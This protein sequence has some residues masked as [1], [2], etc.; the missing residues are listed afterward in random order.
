MISDF[1]FSQDLF[2]A[3]WFYP[4]FTPF[5]YVI[6]VIGGMAWMKRR[7][8]FS[9]RTFSVVHSSILCVASLIMFCG[10]A[11]GALKKARGS[12]SFSLFC[13][14]APE[15]SGTLAFWMYVYWLSKF[16]ELLDTAILVLR[17]KPVIFLHVFHH[18]VMTL[19]PWLWLVGNWTLVWFGCLMNCG[20]HVFMYGYYAASAAWDYRPWWRALLTTSQI[21]QFLMVFVA[22][23]AFQVTRFSG[24]LC[25]GDGN[26]IW[27][28]QGVN[29]VFLFFFVKFFVDT[30]MRKQKE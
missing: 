16:P 21:V 5:L 24:T 12:G 19:M 28:S 22:I 18:A 30:Y 17:K 2:L 23:I 20:I 6:A 26:I 1:V 27:F 14:V 4:V 13:D 9:L 3:Y 7:A 29:L 25:Y 15:Q 10:L 11:Y 8:A